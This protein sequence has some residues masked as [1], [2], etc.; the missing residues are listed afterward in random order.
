MKFGFQI[1]LFDYSGYGFSEG[2]ATRENII[3]DATSAL[4][5]IINSD[6]IQNNKIVV[7]G[8]SLGGN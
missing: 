8:H 4:S 6:N 7:Y 1:F 2:K 5:Y 3:K